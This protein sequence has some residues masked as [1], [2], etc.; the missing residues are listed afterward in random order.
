MAS[1]PPVAGPPPY[2]ANSSEAAAAAAIVVKVE[3]SQ[4][5]RTWMYILCKP[6]RR[7]V[8]DQRWT[9][10]SNALVLVADLPILLICGSAILI[11][12]YRMPDL[13]RKMKLIPERDPGARRDLLVSQMCGLLVDLPFILIASLVLFTGY[14]GVALIRDCVYYAKTAKHRRRA[15]VQQLGN[16]LFPLSLSFFFFSFFSLSVSLFLFIFS[17]CLLWFAF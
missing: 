7:L 10:F 4:D 2:D 9:C 13:I 1:E 14:R 15:A 11:T 8:I 12:F 6:W 17:L 5:L 3:P 16:F